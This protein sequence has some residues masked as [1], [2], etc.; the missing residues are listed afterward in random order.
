[1]GI[2]DSGLT[3]DYLSKVYEDMDIVYHIGDIGYADDAFLHGNPT[4]FKYEKAFNTYMNTIEPM[5]A[6]RPY[7][8]LPGNHE[9]ECHSPACQVD[10]NRIEKLSNFSAYNHRF[11]MP[12]AASGGT[13][14]MWYS[15]NVGPVHFVSIDTET[16]YPGAPNDEYTLKRKNGHFGNQL[17]WLKQDLQKAV[18]NRDKQPWVIVSG[19]RPMYT[20]NNANAKGEPQQDSAILQTAIED[21]L[22]DHQVDM[23]LAGHVHSYERQ[24]PVYNNFAEPSYVNPKFPVHIV[25]GAAGCDEG[26]TSYAKAPNVTWNKYRNDKQW[27][28][29]TMTVYNTT[30][31]LWQFLSVPNGTVLDE[32]VLVK[33]DRATSPPPRP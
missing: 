2:F 27:G 32:F 18:D 6:S 22:F 23:Y 24:S 14:N 11:K 5:A 1:M 15:F 19:H 8:V 9:A 26:H 29:T 20:I 12:Y 28:I 4:E 31:L 7:M 21:L 25:T 30:H 33:T 13:S 3:R 10:P 17:G 16:D